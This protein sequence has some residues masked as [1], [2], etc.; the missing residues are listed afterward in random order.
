[1]TGHSVSVPGAI[2]AADL[3]AALSRLTAAIDKIRTET[4]VD[5]DEEGKARVSLSDRALLLLVFSLL[6]DSRIV[7]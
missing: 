4:S 5:D 6:G 1:M 2:L 3:P 7:M